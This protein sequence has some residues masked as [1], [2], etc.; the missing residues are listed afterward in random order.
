MDLPDRL[1]ADIHKE[2]DSMRGRTL[3][4]IESFGLPERQEEGAKTT[5]KS[6]SYD[7]EAKIMLAVSTYLATL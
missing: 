6:L 7:A 2:C 1:K 5:T 3:G 4:M